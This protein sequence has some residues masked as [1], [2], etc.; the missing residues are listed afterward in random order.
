MRGG[1]GEEGGRQLEAT[2]APHGYHPLGHDQGPLGT[3]SWA[4]LSKWSPLRLPEPPSPVCSR[5]PGAIRAPTPPQGHRPQGLLGPGSGGGGGLSRSGGASRTGFPPWSPPCSWGRTASGPARI[6]GPTL[7]SGENAS[8]ETG[9]LALKGGL[10]GQWSGTERR[11]PEQLPN[12]HVLVVQKGMALC[13]FLRANAHD[14]GPG[15]QGASDLQIR[16][17]QTTTRTDLCLKQRR[18]GVFRGDRQF[19]PNRPQP[20]RN[21]QN[22]PLNR[23]SNRQQSLL[24]PLRKKTPFSHLP[25]QGDGKIPQ[26][27]V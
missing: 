3:I 5:W 14:A 21:H 22:L 20:F 27:F 11:Y 15:L 19:R 17:L 10:G 16:P 23:L 26:E 9:P 7:S 12:L 2:K 8:R 18:A 6:F 4:P 24:Q 25:R 1:G 13:R